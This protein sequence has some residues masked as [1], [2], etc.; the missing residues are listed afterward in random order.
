MMLV[1][2]DRDGLDQH[3]GTKELVAAAS[4]R[5][6]VTKLGQGYSVIS[7]LERQPLISLSSFPY[8]AWRYSW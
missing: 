8:A 2:V 4:D 5:N 6:C 7:M 1:K 3:P